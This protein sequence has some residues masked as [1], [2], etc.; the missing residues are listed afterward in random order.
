MAT[1]L[2]GPLAAEQ[3]PLILNFVFT[4]AGETH[5]LELE[6]AVLGSRTALLS[7]F[8]LLDPAGLSHRHALARARRRPPTAGPGL[9]RRTQPFR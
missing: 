1:R 6:N 9:L 4:D 2:N 3:E 5:V 7:F 8:R